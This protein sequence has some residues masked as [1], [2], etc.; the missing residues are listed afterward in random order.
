M[1]K[2]GFHNLSHNRLVARILSSVLWLSAFP[3]PPKCYA[4]ANQLL[5]LQLFYSS[6]ITSSAFALTVGRESLDP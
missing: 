4:A 3:A 1:L 5:G 6:M 2:K